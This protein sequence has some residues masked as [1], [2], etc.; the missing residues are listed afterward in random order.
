MKKNYVEPVL[1]IETIEENEIFLNLSFGLD[2]DVFDE[3]FGGDDD[4]N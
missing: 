2:F 1:L 4:E 3:V